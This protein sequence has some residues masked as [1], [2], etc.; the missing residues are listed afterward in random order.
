MRTFCFLGILML[1]FW[2]CRKDKEKED[3]I[4][5]FMQVPAIAKYNFHLEQP[6]LITPFDTLI[7]P[8]LLTDN[9]FYSLEGLP[10]LISFYI[11]YDQQSFEEYTTLWGDLGI[12]PLKM[13]AARAT[14]GGESETGDFD[15]S[16][17]EIRPYAMIDNIAFFYF[18]HAVF[19][20]YLVYEMTYDPDDT[21]DIPTVYFRAKE[22]DKDNGI[23]PL[24]PFIYFCTFDLND[25]LLEC[26]N[27]EEK[28]KVNIKYKT[29]TD[30]GKDVYNDWEGNPLELTFK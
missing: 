30:D 1:G 23:F 20:T 18:S 19:G 9:A 29:G 7:A 8:Q 28:L 22:S 5:V 4:E 24:E 26:R 17:E 3:D 16:I 27:S 25:F 21:S 11:N 15:V 12:T 6:T 14:N 2:G 10:L 13:E